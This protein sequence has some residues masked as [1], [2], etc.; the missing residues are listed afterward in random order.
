MPLLRYS[1]RRFVE[2]IPLLL[3]LV[4]LVFFLSRL[5]PGDATTVFLSPN[6][7]PAIVE[8]LKTQ[9]GLDRPAG[10]QYLRWVSSALT[11]DLGYSFS[12]NQPVVSVIGRVFP[13]SL[14]LGIAALCIEIGCGIL[15]ALPV[16]LWEGKKIEAVIAN[17]TL[18]V[19]SLPSFWIGVLLL[20]VFSYGF[21]WLPSSQMY[22]SGIASSDGTSLDLLKHLILPAF[23]AAI[24]AAAGFARYL[25]SSVQTVMQQDYILAA[26]SMGISNKKIFRF[27]ILPNAVAPMVSLIGIEIGLLLTGVLVT[28]TLF[29]WPGMGR[30]TIAAIGARDYPLILGC[31]LVAGVVVIAGNLLADIVN[32]LIDPRVRYVQ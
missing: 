13:N 27:Y 17:T 15:L 12:Y 26:R 3:G 18:A 4:T 9:F 2:A 28:E 7:S 32:A 30:L 5:L 14:I 22:S 11:G 21:G 16:F 29:A 19:Y 25:R 23:T 1:I 6:I 10:E 20:L 31:T 8:Q 24:P